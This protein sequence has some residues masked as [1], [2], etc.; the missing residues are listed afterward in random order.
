MNKVR[1]ISREYADK[2]TCYTNDSNLQYK[3]IADAV[4]YGYSQAKKD[5]ELTWKD[6]HDIVVIE[7]KLIHELCVKDDT[8]PS[9][10]DFYQEILKRF[11]EM[12]KTMNTEE[13]AYNMGKGFVCDVGIDWW[14]DNCKF[15]ASAHI[16]EEYYE[17]APYKFKDLALCEVKGWLE[18]VKA[19]IE[20]TIQSI[21]KNQ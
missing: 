20:G 12:E 11:K 7:D 9:T 17:S 10:K 21:E 15:K 3:A 16:G 1:K 2:N 4:E 13:Y 19:K 18:G 8:F 14:E 5:L 6:I